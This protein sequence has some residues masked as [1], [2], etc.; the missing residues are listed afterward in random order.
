METQAVDWLIDEAD[1]AQQ[2]QEQEAAAPIVAELKVLLPDPESGGG[3]PIPVVRPL[4]L[5]VNRVGRF[6]CSWHQLD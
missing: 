5:G 6:A 4:R 1:Q 2:A 3:A